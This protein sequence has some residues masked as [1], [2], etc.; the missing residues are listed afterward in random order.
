MDFSI[1]FILG[2]VFPAS[3]KISL[4]LAC[5]GDRAMLESNPS[6]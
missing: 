5:Q 3:G 1:V 4:G 6:T 2:I